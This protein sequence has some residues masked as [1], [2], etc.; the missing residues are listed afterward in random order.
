MLLIAIAALLVAMVAQNRQTMLR[1]N[2]LHMRMESL[3][4][5]LAASRD[6]QAALAAEVQAYEVQKMEMQKD[7]RK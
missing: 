6:L 2:A 7:A 5:Q 1:E 3:S 4:Q